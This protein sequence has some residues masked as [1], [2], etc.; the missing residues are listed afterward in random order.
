MRSTS[1][2]TLFSLTEAHASLRARRP[3]GISLGLSSAKAPSKAGSGAARHDDLAARYVQV[4]RAF[5]RGL[6]SR[7]RSSY[8]SENPGCDE[9]F[10]Q[11][12]AQEGR[13][14]RDFTIDRC[15]FA[16][17]EAGASRIPTLDGASITSE[18]VFSPSSESSEKSICSSQALF[19]CSWR[20]KPFKGCRLSATVRL[21]FSR[22]A[23]VKFGTFE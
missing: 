14:S 2:E 17:E 22:I 8:G 1:I 20:Q 3:T 15:I 4:G 11:I 6:G 19:G 13:P 9:E 12:P 16:I 23:C 18:R 7:D 10:H 21:N 5:Q